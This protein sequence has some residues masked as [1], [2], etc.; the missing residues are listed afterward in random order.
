MLEII[1]S[2]CL[3]FLM[4][5]CYINKLSFSFSFLL[6]SF[7]CFGTVLSNYRIDIILLFIAIFIAFFE[8]KLVFQEKR[9]ILLCF[10]LLLTIPLIFSNLILG[11]ILIQAIGK[12]LKFLLIFFIFLASFKFN[13]RDSEVG[14]FI[15]IRQF[16]RIN[17]LILPIGY[18]IGLYTDYGNFQIARFTGIM[19]DSNYFALYCFIMYTFLPTINYKEKA[20]LFIF[21]LLS[22]SW[23][24]LG[25][26]MIYLCFHNLKFKLFFSKY[27]PFLLVIISVVAI[28]FYINNLGRGFVLTDYKEN[29]ISLKINSILFRLEAMSGG[30]IDILKNVD[31]LFWGHGS[32]RSLE[33][34]N[35]VFH[36]F[37]FQFLFD[38]GIFAVVLFYIFL[39]E[40]I[41]KYKIQEGIMWIIFC[42]LSLFFDVYFSFVFIFYFFCY[43]VRLG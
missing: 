13:K 39:Y 22:Q 11:G 19:Q 20:F 27:L 34:S 15:F 38:H 8:H 36:N 4:L 42:I 25:S 17:I 32:G 18:L 6:I 41:K 26:F 2:F 5:G 35:R 21:I 1:I 37:Y 16:I 30:Y 7:I 28:D 23:S 10:I 14:V 33:Y 29:V 24:I 9:L 3:L 43:K 31:S 12:S 40:S